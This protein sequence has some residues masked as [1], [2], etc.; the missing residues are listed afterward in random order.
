MGETLRAQASLWV[1][2]L[3]GMRGRQP[4]CLRAGGARGREEDPAQ[5]HLRG[6]G[7]P[8]M[9]GI[10]GAFAGVGGGQRG[11]VRQ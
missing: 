5:R 2:G 4:P 6:G 8:M 3:E 7:F 1:T 9:E 10:T 11:Q